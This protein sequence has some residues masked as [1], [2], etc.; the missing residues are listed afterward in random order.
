MASSNCW[1]RRSVNGDFEMQPL[2][3]G[4]DGVRIV[5]RV[6]KGSEFVIRVAYDESYSLFGESGLHPTAKQPQG[7]ENSSQRTQHWLR[8][9]ERQND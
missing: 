2:K 7:H 9:E 3:R 1:T 8:P 5:Q 4:G 6:G